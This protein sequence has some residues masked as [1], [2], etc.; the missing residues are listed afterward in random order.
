MM[1]KCRNTTN[2][3]DR[4]QLPAENKALL[5]I[6]YK[7]PSTDHFQIPMENDALMLEINVETV[8]TTINY[9]RKMMHKVLTAV[10]TDTSLRMTSIIH[11]KVMHYCLTHN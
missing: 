5:H 1:H 2:S 7:T 4:S 9:S 10:I 11:R 6:I 8:L 3:I